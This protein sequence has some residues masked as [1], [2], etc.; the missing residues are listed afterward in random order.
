MKP[1][2][3]KKR[4]IKTKTKFNKRKNYNKDRK[5]MPNNNNVGLINRHWSMSRRHVPMFFNV[6]SSLNN[7]GRLKAG[8]FSIN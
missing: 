6:E 7:N 1:K 2:K 8:P 3:K 4:T 5:Q